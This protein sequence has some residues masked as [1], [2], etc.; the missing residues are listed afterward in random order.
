MNAEVESESAAVQVTVVCPLCGGTQFRSYR[1][2]ENARC[3]GCGSKERSR[4]LGLV[5]RRLA[6]PPTR[7]P[8]YHFAPEPKIADILIERYGAAYTPADVDPGSYGWSTVEV[9]QVDLVRPRA[10]IDGPVQGL[11]HSHV[12]EHVPAS[13]DRVVREMNALVEPGG[14]HVFQ[15]PVHDGWY[16]EDMDPD[17]PGVEREARFFQDDHMRSFGRRDFRERVL[18]LFEGFDQVDLAAH[19]RP[20]E[21]ARAAIP[22]SALTSPTGHSV[23][24]FRKRG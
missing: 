2:R 3:A 24:L 16:R 21:L 6:P 7:A 22:A 1:G 18:E 13:L 10:A 19:V 20:E 8:V 17:L 5:L 4:F 15:V 11:V 12:L 14:F 9:R 23:F